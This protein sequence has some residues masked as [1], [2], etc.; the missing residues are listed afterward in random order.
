[1]NIHIYL[2]DSLARKLTLSAHHMSR[3][4]NSIVREAITNWLDLNST[5]TWP[6]SVLN[7]KGIT[8][9]PDTDDLRKNLTD[10]EKA[11]F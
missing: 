11:L 4:R 10:P 3:K 7:F 2:E 1:M 9:F 6:E 5:K 8:D